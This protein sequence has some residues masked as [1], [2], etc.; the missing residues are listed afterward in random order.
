M[1]VASQ[2]ATFLIGAA[3]QAEEAASP[4]CGQTPGEWAAFAVRNALLAA[5]LAR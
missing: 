5:Q 1:A 3:A 4:D 2:Y